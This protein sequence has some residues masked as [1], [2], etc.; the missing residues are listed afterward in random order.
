MLD[1]ASPAAGRFVFVISRREPQIY[2]Y[3]REAFA[4]EGD[5]AVVVDRR[6]GE[7]RHHAAPRGAERRRQDRRIRGDVADDLKSRGCAFVTLD[8]PR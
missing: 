8:A 7:R 6:V 2:E 1:A 3:V 4:L 5:V